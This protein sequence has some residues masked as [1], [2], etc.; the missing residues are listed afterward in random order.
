MV[1]VGIDDNIRN[2]YRIYFGVRNR[3]WRWYIFFWAVG[4]SLINEYIIYKCIHNMHSAPRKYILSHNYFRN[5]MACAWI[6]SEK[7]SAEEFKVHSEILAPRRKIKLDLYS[8]F[9]ESKMTPDR[10]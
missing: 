1:G 4:A 10:A 2:N 6:I 3:K 5:S 7:Y 9:S 8:S